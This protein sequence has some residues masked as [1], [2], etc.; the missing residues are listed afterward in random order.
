MDAK[1][2]TDGQRSYEAKRAAKAGMSLDAWM[3][4]KEKRAKAEAAES[5][6]VTAAEGPA[7]KPGFFTRLM[8]R[9]NKP[10]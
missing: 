4:D 6:K 7:K 5:A 8:E 10:I 3:R 9:A 2:L 1:K